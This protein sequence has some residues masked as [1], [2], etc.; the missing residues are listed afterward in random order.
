M[1]HCRHLVLSKFAIAGAAVLLVSVSSAETWTVAG[2]RFPG[3][4]A[5]SVDESGRSL[6]VLVALRGPDTSADNSETRIVTFGT[7]ADG[8]ASDLSLDRALDMRQPISLRSDLSK[9][10]Y[11]IAH[12]TEDG[13]AVRLFDGSGKQIA[14]YRP[15]FGGS[16][17]LGIISGRGSYWYVASH[18]VFV[19]DDEGVAQAKYRVPHEQYIASFMELDAD[20]CPLTIVVAN[21]V[22]EAWDLRRLCER[23]EALVEQGVSSGDPVLAPDVYTDIIGR[24]RNPDTYWISGPRQDGNI[25]LA[26]CRPLDRSACQSTPFE[27]PSLGKPMVASHLPITMMTGGGIVIAAVDDGVSSLLIFDSSGHR[28]AKHELRR[29]NVN[30]PD[31]TTGKISFVD[32]VGSATRAWS[33]SMAIEVVP[34]APG[35]SDESRLVFKIHSDYIS[36]NSSG[37]IVTVSTN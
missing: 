37:D 2:N 13:A 9:G 8:T 31:R 21:P 29:V 25:G 11:V 19:L 33:L 36:V 35:G 15:D 32:L 1:N 7:N 30:D 17:V 23:K 14:D 28:R 34:P 4:Q 3:V 20:D 26:Q 6:S 12:N 5:V 10:Q 24:T 16:G 22:A 27:L 18:G